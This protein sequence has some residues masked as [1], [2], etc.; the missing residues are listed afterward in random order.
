MT[1]YIYL[2][3]PPPKLTAMQK[4]KRILKGLTLWLLGGL[5]LNIV[6]CALVGTLWVV[7]ILVG[8]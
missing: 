7:A 5:L 6:L 4:A 3:I 1:Q 8:K 2:N